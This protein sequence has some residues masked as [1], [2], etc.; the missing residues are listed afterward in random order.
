MGAALGAAIVFPPLQALLIFTMLGVGMATPYVAL[1]FMPGVMKR[2][3]RPGAWMETLK[4]VLS[5]P[6]FA[7][8]IWLIW[9]FGQQT[10]LDGMVLLLALECS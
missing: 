3:P 1:S 2:L 9:V 4:Q 7:T 8:T 6:M 10:G 5:F